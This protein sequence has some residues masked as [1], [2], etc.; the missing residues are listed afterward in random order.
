MLCLNHATNARES[1]GGGCIDKWLDIV[2][3]DNIHIPFAKDAGEPEDHSSA[4]SRWFVHAH[5][6]PAL[7]FYFIRKAT[8]RADT[9]ESQIEPLAVGV[10]SKFHQELLHA[11]RI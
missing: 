7:R 6:R 8:A 3:V 2:G 11:A 1:G 4:E 9:Q 10:P 5:H